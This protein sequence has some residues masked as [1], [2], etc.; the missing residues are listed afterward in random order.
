MLQEEITRIQSQYML[1]EGVFS[2]VKDKVKAFKDKVVEAIK[3]LYEKIIKKFIWFLLEFFSQNYDL[4]YFF[5]Y[6]FYFYFSSL[7]C[8]LFCVNNFL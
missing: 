8:F 2:W 6:N 4:L 7:S 5:C 1:N 3:M